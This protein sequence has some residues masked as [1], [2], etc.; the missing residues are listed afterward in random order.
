MGLLACVCLQEV[1]GIPDYTLQ[2]H[3]PD[4]VLGPADPVLVKRWSDVGAAESLVTAHRKR[5]A[6]QGAPAGGWGARV[7]CKGPLSVSRNHKPL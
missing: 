3:P 5:L 6:R 7:F 2:H 1:D 4:D